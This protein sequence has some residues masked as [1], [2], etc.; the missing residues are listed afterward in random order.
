M[1]GCV[2]L[3]PA[4]R[5]KKDHADATN[6]ILNRNVS[7]GRKDA[8]VGGVIAVVAE[9]EQVTG[10]DGKDIG[11]VV[12]TRVDTIQR[13]VTRSLRQRLA[14]AKHLSRSAAAPGQHA[15]RIFDHC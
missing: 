11:I 7:H 5:E 12:E 15:S 2:P 10:W 14:P 3:P 6:D 4:S 1:A 8:T 13:L 9:H